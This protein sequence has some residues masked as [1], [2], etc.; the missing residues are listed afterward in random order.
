MEGG[1]K[2]RR[3]LPL[4]SF[5]P[6]ICATFAHFSLLSVLTFFCYY[7]FT[8]SHLHIDKKRVGSIETIFSEVC[9]VFTVLYNK[10]FYLLIL[11]SLF[12]ISY[13][14]FVY[15]YRCRFGLIHLVARWAWPKRFPNH[16]IQVHTI[17]PLSLCYFVFI[18]SLSLLARSHCVFFVYDVSMI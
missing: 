12:P 4:S 3:R 14:R 17:S 16:K 6:L 10:K 5:S 13:F 8:N 18:F 9:L 2:T 7:F 11:F 1:V 15:L